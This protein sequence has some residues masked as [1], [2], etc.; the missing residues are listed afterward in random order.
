MYFY[1]LWISVETISD[2]LLGILG[3]SL[4]KLSRKVQSSGGDVPQSLLVSFAAKWGEPRE[5][6]VGQ[7]PQ[8]PDVRGK[9][10]RLVGE[11]LGGCEE[12]ED[13]R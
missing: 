10:D 4:E 11:N 7:H 3:H 8:G 6:N 9:T 12:H 13:V 5:E 2:E 1:S